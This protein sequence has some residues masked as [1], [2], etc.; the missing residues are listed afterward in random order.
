[1]ELGARRLL[2]KHLLAIDKYIKDARWIDKG[3]AQSKR[4]SVTLKSLTDTAKIGSDQLLNQDFGKRFEKECEKL[5]A[6]RVRLEFPGRQ[7][8]VVRRKVVIAGHRLSETLSEGEQKV[9]ALADFLAETSLKRTRAPVVFDDPI[10]SLDYKRIREVAGRILD[11]SK[12]RQVIVFTHNIWFATELLSRFEDSPGDCS[13]YDI[14]SEGESFGLVSK[15]THP[16]ADTFKTDRA[17]I[18]EAVQHAKKATGSVQDALIEKGYEY[19]RNVCEVIVET[20][21]LRGVT[22]RYQ[23]NVMMTKLP[24]IKTDRLQAAI[25]GIMPIFEKACRLIASHSQPM[26]TLNVRPSLVDLESDWKAVQDLRDTY[27]KD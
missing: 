12:E 1:M 16:R 26:E 15:G 21:L 7:G 19:L 8:Q 9:I 4:F 3:R 22:Q 20:D 25:D 18:N 24:Q 23:P 6:P 14:R 2:A 13:Y 27:V 11:L 5:R 17:K 10:T